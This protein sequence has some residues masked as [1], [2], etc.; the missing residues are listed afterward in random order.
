MATIKYKGMELE[1]IT[2][3]QIFDP[4]KTM[5]VDDGKN[6][7]RTAIVTAILAQSSG[8]SYRVLTDNHLICYSRCALL[9]EKPVPRRA[10][11]RELAKWLAKGK[12]Q[13]QYDDKTKNFGKSPDGERHKALKSTTIFEYFG[14]DDFYVG[15]DIQVRKWDDTEWHEPTVD[16]MEIEEKETDV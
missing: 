7:P 6:N 1:E 8:H 11:N 16:Y 9:P 3:P 14:A 15:V 5:V 4:P 12:G 10:T 2:E 13:I